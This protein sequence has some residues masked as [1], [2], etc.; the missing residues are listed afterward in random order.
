MTRETFPVQLR[1]DLQLSNISNYFEPSMVLPVK[2]LELESVTFILPSTFT[3]RPTWNLIRWNGAATVHRINKQ[4]IDD[5][6]IQ[7]EY[8]D[9]EFTN[10]H[11]QLRTGDL[12]YSCKS[13]CLSS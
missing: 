4:N 10:P 7:M 8:I 12:R 13:V 6:H 2:L 1:L 5:K 9:K 11:T 3:Y